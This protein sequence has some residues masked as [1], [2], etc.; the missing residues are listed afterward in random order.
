[1]TAS[2][3]ERGGDGV[4]QNLNIAR[5]YYAAAA[6]Q[7]DETAEL[8]FKE[9]SARLKTQGPGSGAGADHGS[10]RATPQ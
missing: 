10:P 7:G 9:L 2:F 6:A 3:Y 5:A 8:K 4:T 1:M